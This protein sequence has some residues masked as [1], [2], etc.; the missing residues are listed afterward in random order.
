[1]SKNDFESM[2]DHLSFIDDL[3]TGLETLRAHLVDLEAM[4]HAA[5]QTLDYLPYVPHASGSSNPGAPGSERGGENEC[6]GRSARESRA[7]EVRT[8]MDR[9]QA[10]VHSTARSALELLTEA[11]GLLA[12]ARGPRGR[13][14]SSRARDARLPYGGVRLLANT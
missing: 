11:N 10:L 13:N 12:A 6:D 3:V 2:V 5:S 8:Q 1:M 4:A 9:L 7:R 14:G